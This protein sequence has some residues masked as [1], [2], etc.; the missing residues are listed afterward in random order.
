MEGK[1]YEFE[2]ADNR[3][4]GDEA[5]EQAKFANYEAYANQMRQ[6]QIASTSQAVG[7]GEDAFKDFMSLGMGGG[8]P[9]G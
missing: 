3:V 7:A 9:F 1:A 8:N 6:E 2:A 4:A 5:I